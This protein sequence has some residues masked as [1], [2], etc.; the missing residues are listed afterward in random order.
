MGSGEYSTQGSKHVQGYEDTVR[1]M[2]H[3]RMLFSAKEEVAE[4]KHH[5]ARVRLRANHGVRL[6]RSRLP[7]RKHRCV[8]PV[9]DGWDEKTRRGVVDVALSVALV[10]DTVKGIALLFCSAW[11]CGRGRGG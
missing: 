9:Q 7:V 1:D 4:G 6:A 2:V 10:E 3:G 11:M 5:D 8:V